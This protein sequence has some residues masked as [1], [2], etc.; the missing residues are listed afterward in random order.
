LNQDRDALIYIKDKTPEILSAY[1]RSPWV[2]KPASL[3]ENFSNLN[4]K[5]KFNKLINII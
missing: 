2:F 1:Q 4:E 5:E 3:F